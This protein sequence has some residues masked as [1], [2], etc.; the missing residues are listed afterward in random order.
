VRTKILKPEHGT[1]LSRLLLYAVIP[2]AIINSYQIA[3]SAE[4]LAGLGVAILGGVI[5][6]AV[7]YILERLLRRPLRLH[8]VESASIFYSNAGNLVMPLVLASLGEEWVFYVSGYMLVQQLLI[9]THGKSLVSGTRQYDIK[10]MLTNVNILAIAVGIALFLTGFRLPSVMQTTVDA[11]A[12]MLAPLSMILTGML[13]GGMKWREIVG[14]PRAYL[15]TALRLVIFPLVVV[16][17]FAVTGITKLH[18]DAVNI[19]TVTMLA[20]ASASATTVTQFAQL[21]DQRPGYTSVISIMT[22][23]FCIVTIPLMIG[24]YQWLI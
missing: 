14:E 7:F 13:L 23:L 8:P 9:W 2:C 1:T 22:V 21:Y 5:A 4:K 6:H 24:L 18:P 20:T 16:L 10:K 17:I 12:G 19:L 15:I 11:L 3:Y